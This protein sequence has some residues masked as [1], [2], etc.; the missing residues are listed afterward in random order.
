MSHDDSCTL[1]REA[2]L[3]T[4]LMMGH[5]SCMLQ[6]FV[7]PHSVRNVGVYSGEYGNFK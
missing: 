3:S 7:H 5:L 2:N 6:R 1:G 4:I